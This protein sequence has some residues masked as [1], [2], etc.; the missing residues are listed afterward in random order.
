MKQVWYCRYKTKKIAHCCFGVDAHLD[1]DPIS[2]CG[3]P[4]V[5]GY[6]RFIIIFSSTNPSSLDID[7]DH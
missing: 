5:K 7:L 6:R 4:Q 1:D 2:N 3:M